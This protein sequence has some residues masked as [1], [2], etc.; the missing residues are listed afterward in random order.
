MFL[1]ISQDV[2][3]KLG[4]Y[5]FGQ[6]RVHVIILELPLYLWVF[7]YKV[8]YIFDHCIQYLANTIFLQKDYRALKKPRDNDQKKGFW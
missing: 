6:A 5:V 2:L 4:N 7:F 8:A 1:F 3:D